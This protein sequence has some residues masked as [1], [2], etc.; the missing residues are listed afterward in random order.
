MTDLPQL[1]DIRRH[2]DALDDQLLDILRQRAELIQKVRPLKP[3][4][5]LHIRAG[6]EA[7]MFRRLFSRPQ[8]HL[9]PQLVYAVWRNM[10]G[11]F[12]AQ[13]ENFVVAAVPETALCA[14]QNFGLMPEITVY[15][16][17]SALWQTTEKARLWDVALLPTPADGQAAWWADLKHHRDYKIFM[18]LPLVAGMTPPAWVV[19][20][21]QPEE[22]G[23]DV[24]VMV[25]AAQKKVDAAA[26]I[27]KGGQVLVEKVDHEGGK[28]LFLWKNLAEGRNLAIPAFHDLLHQHGAQLHYLGGFALPV[29]L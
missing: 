26:I 19:G 4:G 20:K 3:S 15:E 28:T 27:N 18:S 2:L 16:T 7:E 1:N 14:H 17:T 29:Q 24:A 6:R 12:T 21:I 8:G 5:Q 11:S 9:P 23:D 25:I 10:I 13:E 22:T